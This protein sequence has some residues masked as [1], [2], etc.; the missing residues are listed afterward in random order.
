MYYVP[1][2]KIIVIRMIQ[3]IIFTADNTKDTIL[4][5][6][7]LSGAYTKKSG[8]N[9]SGQKLHEIVSETIL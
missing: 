8:K 9:M 5:Q 7:K 1:F 3:I 6:K 2:V 4:G